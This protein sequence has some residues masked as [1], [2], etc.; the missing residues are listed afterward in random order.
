MKRNWFRIVAGI[1]IVCALA[2]G[3]FKVLSPREPSFEGRRLTYWV[4][5][6]WH[7]NSSP[8]GPEKKKARAVVRHLGAKSVPLLLH[9]LQQEVRPS[10]TQRFDELRQGIFLWFVRHKLIENRSIT[11]LQ[12]FN[13]S[14]RGMA[15]TVLAELGPEGRKI[16]IPSL[17][18]MLRERDPRSNEPSI[19]AR[20]SG[21]TLSKM[22]PESIPPLMA[23]LTNQ[24]IQ[25][26]GLA[27]GALGNIGPEAKAAIPML[28]EKLMD[29]DPAVRMGVAETI[30]KLGGDPREFV[31]I[32]IGTLPELKWDMLDYGL[33]V[34]LR[35]KEH[36]KAA[37]PVLISILNKTPISTNKTNIM[38][39]QQVGFA[40][41]EIDPEAAAKAG[42]K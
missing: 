22:A 25:V 3:G 39:R 10:M 4:W 32:L 19:T 23:A 5:T 14:H 8:E 30:G 27:A 26:W 31:P 12:D 16:A 24:D 17:I 35:D 15:M 37:V 7:M 42:V 36:A 38:V 18:Q 9:W 29:K 1:L 21:L 33:E 20:V 6:M 34:L 41:R 11:S 28:K 2:A 40:L 13:P